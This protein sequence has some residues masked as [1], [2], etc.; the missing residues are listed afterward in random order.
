M[1]TLHHSR[2]PF[3][4]LCVVVLVLWAVQGAIAQT[5]VTHTDVLN[6]D[7]IVSELKQD[8]IL[9]RSESSPFPVSYGRNVTTVY[10]DEKGVAISIDSVKSGQPVTVYYIKT[11]NKLAASKIIVRRVAITPNSPFK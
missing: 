10:V 2:F 6:S 3:A 8:A 5:I 7:G 11:G 1:K 4:I 9:V